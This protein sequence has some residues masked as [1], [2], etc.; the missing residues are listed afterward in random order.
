MIND[1]KISDTMPSTASGETCPSGLA[2]FAATLSGLVPMSPNTTPMH[3]SAAGAHERALPSRG[4]AS[5]FAV[6]LIGRGLRR[7]T[8]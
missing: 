1:Q 7:M 2:D 8:A 6:A 5:I 4:A 3:A